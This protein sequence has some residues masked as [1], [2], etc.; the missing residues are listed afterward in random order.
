MVDRREGEILS[1]GELSAASLDLFEHA[2]YGCV[3]VDARGRIVRANPRAAELTGRGVTKLIGTHVLELCGA[4]PAGRAQ[5]ERLF[6]QLVAGEEFVEEPLEIQRGDGTLARV[7]LT[8]RPVY[9]EGRFA[10]VLGLLVDA[11]DVWATSPAVGMDER[12]QAAALASVGN[13]VM[14]TDV[15]GTIVWVNEA[16]TQMSGYAA[17]EAIGQ[18]PRLLKSG[19]Q[20]AAHY[21]E[22]WA[23]I[24][25]RRIWRGEIV[26]RRKDGSL[27]TVWQTITPILDA[28]GTITH[29]VAVHED[30]T[31]LRAS[32]GQ[33]QAI[34]DHAL[35]AIVLFD[36]A[37]GL[38]ATNPAV[39]EL[40]GYPPEQLA[41]LSM[42]ELVPDSSRVLYDA[43]WE[44]FEARG[45]TRARLPVRRADGELR[46]VEYQAVADIADGVHLLIARDMTDQHR[47]QAQQRFQAQVLKA[48]GDAVIATDLDGIVRYTN[49]AAERLFG[50]AETHV[51]GQYLGD[52][53]DDLEA[54][55]DIHALL[56]DGRDIQPH[57]RQATVARADG[58]SFTALVT[59]TPYRDARGQTTGAIALVADVSDLEATRRLLDR[60]AR[61]QAAVAQVGQEAMRTNDPR[62]VAE[63]A[64]QIADEL[65]GDDL[66]VGLDWRPTPETARP[67]EQTRIGIGDAGALTVNGPGAGSLS[68]QDGEFLH[69]LAHVLQAT[70]QRHAATT[71]LE[72]L[73]THDPLTGLANRTLFLDRLEQAR[74]VCQRHGGRF[75]VLF[76][77]LDGFKT[78]NDGLGH[79]TGDEVL[80]EIADRLQHTVRPTDTLSRFGGDEFAMLCPDIADRH[81]AA[82]IARRIHTTLA[83]GVNTE[84]GAVSLTASIG[85]VFGDHTTSGSALLRDADTAMYE[86][87]AAGRN[88]AQVFDE[89]MQDQAHQ[90]FRNTARLQAALDEG[91]IEVRYQPTIELAS[92]RIVG[93]EALARLRDTDGSLLAPGEFI[94]LAEETGLIT[95]LGE[96]VLR[97]ACTDARD[98]IA[99]DPEFM[100][101]VNLSPRQITHHDIAATIRRILD[102]T[103]LDPDRLWLEITESALLAGP[104]VHAAMH[105]LRTHGIRFAIDDFGTGYSSLAHLR[106]MPVDMLKIDRSFVSGLQTSIQDHALV[107]ATIY[108]ARTFGLPTTAEGVETHDQLAEL[109]DLGCDYA[110]GYHWSTPTDPATIT[111]MLNDDTGPDR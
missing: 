25:D 81:G 7:R 74:A 75:A 63:L 104:G 70:L 20:R 34:F 31:A 100:L 1:A 58:S 73:A 99:T 23:T 22:L 36:D 43:L 53:Y 108:L 76:F 65:L 60:R 18:T 64:R 26:D 72:H 86:A 35:D 103:G 102:D 94:P 90:R 106:Q 41:R 51:L 24:R 84:Q 39:A 55:A 87:K 96:Q 111:Q 98:W 42:A 14:V 38:V 89:H 56:A 78:I 21:E 101:S 30:V 109:T 45:R 37:G 69:A 85:I 13:A 29:F 5:A 91:R 27:Y 8:Q 11:D 67:V 49:P 59:I 3:L 17:N 66:E 93:V 48:V 15:E 32:Q 95:T 9:S 83:T 19:V 82:I 110:Q 44:Q 61:Q 68:E 47:A 92:G 88:R 105:Q 77:D 16:F 52:V 79:E 10:G 57:T 50:L 28:S 40:T 2:P 80:R 4:T 71:Q 54:Q 33:L 107:T 46:E 62:A 97:R 12:L 6:A